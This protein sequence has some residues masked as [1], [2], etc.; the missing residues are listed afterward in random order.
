M[1]SYFYKDIEDKTWNS[2]VKKIILVTLQT[3]KLN[4]TFTDVFIG[5]RSE[6]RKPIEWSLNEIKKIKIKCENLKSIFK[7]WYK[8]E[9]SDIKSF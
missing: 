5:L 3:Y 7:N 4:S 9:K 2:W 6:I 1:P 8:L